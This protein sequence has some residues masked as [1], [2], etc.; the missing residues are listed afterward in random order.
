MLH[1]GAYHHPHLSSSNFPGVGGGGMRGLSQ[2]L[3]CDEILYI[4]KT[5]DIGCADINTTFRLGIANLSFNN[6]LQGCCAKHKRTVSQ[7]PAKKELNSPPERSATDNDRPHHFYDEIKED[8][9]QVSITA[10][11]SNRSSFFS[12]W[13]SLPNLPNFLV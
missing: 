3:R 7:P 9:I 1:A 8:E 13:I 10:R 11:Y 12:V 5:Q 6:S 4:F 2:L